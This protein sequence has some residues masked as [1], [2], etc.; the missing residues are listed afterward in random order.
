MG[1]GHTYCRCNLWPR[2]YPVPPGL[3]PPKRG[4]EG[5]GRH[6]GQD[7]HQVRLREA[8]GPSNQAPEKSPVPI[9]GQ[10]E[11]KGKGKGRHPPGT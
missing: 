3:L 9:E 5:P 2:L 6:P 10:A 8:Q 1:T 4:E 11:V 7:M